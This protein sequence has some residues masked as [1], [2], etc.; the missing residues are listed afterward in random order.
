MEIHHIGY[1]V[2]DRNSEQE[3]IAL[4]YKKTTEWIHDE[5]RKIEICFMKN[6]EVVVELVIPDKDCTIIGKQLRKLRNLPYHICYVCDDIEKKVDELEK[7]G[8][9]VTSQPEVAPAI[10]N[11]RVAFLFGNSVGV[12]ELVER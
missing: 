1:L 6:S 3:F 5:I 4:G 2:H 8:W 10:G 12:V 9:M 7:K 11:K